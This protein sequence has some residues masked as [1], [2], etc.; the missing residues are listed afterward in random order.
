MLID[1][2]EMSKTVF[3]Y[4]SP[5]IGTHQLNIYSTPYIR[6]INDL[7]LQHDRRIYTLFTLLYFNI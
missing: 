6:M 3:I 5:K 7:T 2:C 1:E 4:S